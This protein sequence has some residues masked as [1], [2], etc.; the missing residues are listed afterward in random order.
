MSPVSALESPLG[1]Q[2]TIESNTTEGHQSSSIIV[3]LTDANQR[4]DH[5][6]LCKYPGHSR[7]YL[8][9]LIATAAVLVCGIKVKSGYR[10]KANDILSVVFPPAQP[11]KLVPEEVPFS[12]FYE[13]AHLLVIGKPPGTVVHP[14]PGHHSGTLAHG[15][16]YHCGSLPDADAGRP[17][18]VHR[19][20][21]D[22]SGVMLVAKTEMVLRALMADF[23]ER[24]I[25]KSYQALLLRT[26]QASEGRIVV[27]IGR[28]PVMRKKMAVRPLHGKFAA[29]N[30]HICE[31][32]PNGW[33]LA[34]VGI[35]TGRT[36]QIR[37][38]MAYNK[39]PVVGDEL[40]G[41]A[42]DQKSALKPRRQ[43]LHASTLIFTH[44]VTRVEHTFTVPLW[45][46]MRQL[47]EE[48]R[49]QGFV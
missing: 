11:S 20:D 7:S 5:F 44:P 3:G 12:I 31:T 42:V 18:I 41:G 34:N 6:L 30:W 37:V 46:D 26:P 32:F 45:D 49:G 17:G 47:V 21:K 23:K 19:L 25:K 4:L 36:H 29:T 24:K 33:C 43:M 9:K 1:G 48:L 2:C 39:T 40:Y 13:D 27:P 14:A 38:H 22:T 8:H 35:E 10:L 15:L 28:H 16:A